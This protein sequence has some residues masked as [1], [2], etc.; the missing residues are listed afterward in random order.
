MAHSEHNKP[1]KSS[2]F[3]LIIFGA[4]LFIIAPTWFSKQPEI[5]LVAIVLGFV[6]GGIGFYIRFIRKQK[7]SS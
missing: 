3:F 1:K 4:L 6:V 5:G 2:G 7:Y